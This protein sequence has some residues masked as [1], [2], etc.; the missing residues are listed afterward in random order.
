MITFTATEKKQDEEH[1]AIYRAVADFTAFG[2][3]GNQNLVA[4]VRLENVY[5]KGSDCLAEDIS[6]VGTDI[7][8]H[9]PEG[10]LIPGQLYTPCVTNKLLD[11]ESGYLDDWDITLFPYE[12]EIPQ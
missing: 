4:G 1:L 11:R 5:I 6:N 12:G 2:I 10:G 7:R 9:L 8:L 3:D